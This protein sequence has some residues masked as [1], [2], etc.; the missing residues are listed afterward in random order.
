MAKGKSGL[1]WSY[2][3]AS[4]MSMF[5][6]FLTVASS[7][8]LGSTARA[9]DNPSV[10]YNVTVEQAMSVSVSSQQI[11]LL[12]NPAAYRPFDSQDLNVS[13]TTNNKY[14]YELFMSANSTDLTNANDSTEKINTLPDNGDTGYTEATF[15][16]NKWGYKVG[17]GN[18]F[19]FV[20]GDM[21]NS[22]DE[23][24]INHVTNLNF[25]AKADMTKPAGTY[26]NTLVFSAVAKS[27]PQEMQ[28]L[29]PSLC[30]ST[31]TVVSDT[32]DAKL[33]TI[34]RLADGQCWM[35]SD[36]NLAGGTKLYS[37]TS[38][39][40]AGYPK[41]EGTGYF[42]LPASSTDGFNDN[43]AAFVYNSGNTTT[44]QADCTNSQPC[45]SYYSWLTATAGGKD[46]NGNAVTG[47]GLDT[48]YSVCPKG[49]R[50]PKSG[51]NSD[52]SASST[53]GYKKGDFYKLATAYGANQGSSSADSSS[54][55]GANFYNN[56]GPDTL[57]NFLLAGNYD[58]SSFGNGG[59]Y[60][61]YWSS[62]SYTSTNAY[63]LLFNSSRVSSAAYTN[64]RSGFPVRCILREGPESID[65][66]E[67]MQQFGAL[68]TSKRTKIIGT[69]DGTKTYTLKDERDNK[70]YNIAKLA[71]GQVWMT[72]SLNLAGGTAL[73]SDDS[74][75]AAANTRASGT[76][77]YTLPTS[78]QSGFNDDTAAF[79]YNANGTN[80]PAHGSTAA[81]T[82]DPSSASDGCDSYYSWLAATAGGKDSSGN[83]VTGNG[84]DTAYS[85]CPKGWRLPKSG[86]SSD[87]SASST[88]GYKKGDFYKL[89][90]A[91]GAN[92]ESQQYESAATFY[93]NAGPGTLPNFLLAGY[94]YAGSFT[95]GGSYGRYWSSS[96]RS[97]TYA[98]SLYF[99]SSYVYSASNR[100][101]LYGFPVRCILGGS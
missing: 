78:S 27:A 64:R 11:S 13:V 80:T 73:Y 51:D 91:Y 35:V 20:S 37:E 9:V 58:S 101:R 94:Y 79:V 72:S 46:A 32:R 81:T 97:T 41:S 76:P 39:V 85:V 88:T 3:G 87:T 22:H 90:T 89:A 96:S 100:N 31:P 10:E 24:A 93:N 65:D 59:S 40:P 34:A 54:S 19:P 53:T 8:L 56:A 12:L 68:N 75:V 57:P 43:T 71:D 23:M 21:I 44:D 69:M 26:S 30:T 7:T 6:L 63:R 29:N 47:N 52:T 61:Y 55:T 48:A 17:T 25:A 15:I 1:R 14:G 70:Y 5:F 42:T 95:N 84:L 4:T 74:D 66:I 45:N 50:L 82:C 83:D 18:Y 16:D 98:Y 99:Y 67:T 62:S 92:L 33:Y 38:D 2:I 77:Y 28:N 86:D 36:L 49:W 60:G